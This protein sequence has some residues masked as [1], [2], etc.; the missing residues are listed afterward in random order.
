[1]NKPV[2]IALGVAM[3]LIGA[4]AILGPCITFMDSVHE[5]HFGPVEEISAAIQA[6]HDEQSSSLEESDTAWP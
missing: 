5:I 4:L 6:D 3:I 2:F 1:M